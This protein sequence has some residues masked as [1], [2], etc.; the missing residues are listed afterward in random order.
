[1]NKSL[2]KS[3]GLIQRNKIEEHLIFE[4]VLSLPGGVNKEQELIPQRT[5][6]IAKRGDEY[7]ICVCHNAV[8]AFG[9]ER[10]VQ[11]LDSIS[12]VL[13]VQ[14]SLYNPHMSMPIQ[15][16]RSR[17]RLE[18]NSRNSKIII[19]TD[20]AQARFSGVLAMLFSQILCDN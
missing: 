15:Q 5:F 10:S 17:N 11:L 3:K 2:Q 1:M 18:K 16:L 7:S 20:S 8:I 4:I 12:I 9:K 14:V 13:G 6:K 19:S